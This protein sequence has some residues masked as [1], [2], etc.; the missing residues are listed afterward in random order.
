MQ[1]QKNFITLGHVTCKLS[2]G[3]L[4][5]G[6]PLLGRGLT[7]GYEVE[8]RSTV[9]GRETRDPRDP[10]CF[11]YIYS[12]RSFS[13]PVE[14]PRPWRPPRRLW[15]QADMS[16]AEEAAMSSL[17][18]ELNAFIDCFLLLHSTRL[19]NDQGMFLRA[20]AS[21]VAG[22]RVHWPGGG[23]FP[24]PSTLQLGQ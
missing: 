17:S 1:P 12:I 7:S 23:G 5:L 18:M 22:G 10:Q 8:D 24:N 9:A 6:A 13:T 21:T 20:G 11:A 16:A 19:P 2:L 14:S 4:L 3:P 15:N